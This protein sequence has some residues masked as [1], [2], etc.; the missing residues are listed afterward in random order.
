MVWDLRNAQPIMN[1]PGHHKTI[2]S[3]DFSDNGYQLA[4]GSKDNTVKIWELRRSAA[5]STL[6]LHNKLISDVKFQHQGTKNSSFLMTCSYDGFAKV[7]SCLDYLEKYSVFIPQSRLSSVSMS[8]SKD[9]F[10]LTSMEKNLYRYVKR[11]EG[12]KEDDIMGD[13]DFLN[14]LLM[15]EI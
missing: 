12:D 13:G 3:S 4:T 8:L 6:P 14:N 10:M 15:D 1:L 2:L 11:A 7:V 9:Y 5:S